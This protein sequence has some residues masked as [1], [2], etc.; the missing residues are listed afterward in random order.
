[1]S[2]LAKQIT[3]W[4]NDDDLHFHSNLYS[5]ETRAHGFFCRA[6]YSPGERAI[7]SF[8]AGSDLQIYK[9]W[10]TQQ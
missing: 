10:L 1:M 3:L 9:K 7:K 5:Y 2:K 6:N 8:N 4:D